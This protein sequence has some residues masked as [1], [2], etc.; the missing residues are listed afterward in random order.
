MSSSLIL[1]LTRKLI[2]FREHAP[3]NRIVSSNNSVSDKY[4]YIYIYTYTFILSIF[5]KPLLADTLKGSFSVLALRSSEITVVS[6]GLTLIY[7]CKSKLMD[8]LSDWLSS[9]FMPIEG[10]NKV[11]CLQLNNATWSHG[12]L[13]GDVWPNLLKFQ[14]SEL[15]SDCREW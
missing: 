10:E 9:T 7:V 8:R 11:Q 4:I 13:R 14:H 3:N 2:I 1:E 15:S 6:F 12:S 5:G